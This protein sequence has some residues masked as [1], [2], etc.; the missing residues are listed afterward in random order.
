M[1]IA[2]A[3]DHAA[4]TLKRVIVEHLTDQGYDVRDLGT[5]D[6]S[7]SVDYPDYGAAVGRAVATGSAELGVALCGSGIG[8]AIAANKIAGVRAAVITDATTGRLAREHNHANVI[9][10]GQR[11]TGD[12]TALDAVDAFFSAVPQGGRHLARLAKLAALDDAASL[13][14]ETKES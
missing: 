8:I 5:N 7:V 3:A 4:V 9:C 1:R 13:P 11:T 14:P 10:L 12:A 6:A 2:V